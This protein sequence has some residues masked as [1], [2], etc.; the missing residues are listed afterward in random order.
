M[1][2]IDGLVFDLCNEIDDWKAEAEYWKQK[3]EELNQ[4]YSDM[5]DSSIKA[6]HRASLGML[7]IALNDEDL[8]KVVAGEDKTHE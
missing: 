1:S 4:K 8:A 6:S 5:L 7:A 3:Y 2:R